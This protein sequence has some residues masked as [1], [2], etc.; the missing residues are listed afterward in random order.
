MAPLTDHAPTAPGE[1]GGKETF[2][3]GGPFVGL[4]EINFEI[5]F[6]KDNFPFTHVSGS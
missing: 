5:F 2:P 3:V 6:N 4:E 1:G